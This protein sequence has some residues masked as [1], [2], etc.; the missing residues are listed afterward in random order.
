M[1]IKA[2]VMAEK[3]KAEIREVEKPKL[4]DGYVLVK[5]KAVAL[6]PLDWKNLEV[7]FAPGVR[8][9]ADYAGII[10]EVG[11][12][13]TKPFKKGDRIA[14]FVNC[15]NSLQPE[16]GA[17]GEYLVAKASVQIKIPDN[18]TD[19]QAATLGVSVITIGQS[20]YKHMGLPWPTEP[21]KEPQPI[22]VHGASSASGLYGV[23][24]LK[25]SGFTVIA[26][27]SPHNFEY[28]K[29]LGASAVFDY[30][31]PTAAAEIKALTHNKLKLAWDCVGTGAELIASALSDVEESKF[32]TIMS[33]D[34]D[35]VRR[36]NPKVDGPHFTLG[37]DVIGEPY[38]W[39]DKVA[40]ALPEEHDYIAEFVEIVPKLLQDGTV[41]PIRTFVNRGGAGL[42]G[43]LK[44]LEELKAGKVSGGKLVYTL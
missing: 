23:Q 25:A 21:A 9:G 40:P 32:W 35:T 22:L 29:S 43:V 33:P 24:F 37:Y 2:V 10:E 44:G 13:V 15:S 11:P 12:G 39:I 26:T 28:L 42:E 17:F 5:V 27:A 18:I 4:R 38:Q 36:I 30:H 19:E 3:G 20:L 41:K 1:A 34:E 31:S 16:D 7:R 8:M 6:N 14:G